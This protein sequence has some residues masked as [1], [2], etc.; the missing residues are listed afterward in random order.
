MFSALVTYS[1]VDVYIREEKVFLQLKKNHCLPRQGHCLDLYGLGLLRLVKFMFSR[2]DYSNTHFL[3]PGGTG[4]FHDD[5][6]VKEC[7]RKHET[8]FLTD[9]PAQSSD[10][11]PIE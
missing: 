2:P 7:F 10:I 5:K 6:T 4:I 9:W 8:S 3:F 11:K 1:A